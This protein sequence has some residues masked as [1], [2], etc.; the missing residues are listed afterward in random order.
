MY[1]DSYKV[2]PVDFGEKNFFLYYLGTYL[3]TNFVA[4]KEFIYFVEY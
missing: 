4:Y 2:H 1:T 3:L